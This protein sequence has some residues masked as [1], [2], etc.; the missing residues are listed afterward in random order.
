MNFKD[1]LSLS[2]SGR[3]LLEK[4][5]NTGVKSYYIKIDEL[6]SKLNAEQLDILRNNFTGNFNESQLW[7]K[8]AE[9]M[10]AHDYLDIKPLNFFMIHKVSRI[11]FLNKNNKHS[12]GKHN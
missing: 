3:K 8:M 11:F 2:K 5:N 12:T 9:L 6:L 1:L 4:D 7:D 10:V